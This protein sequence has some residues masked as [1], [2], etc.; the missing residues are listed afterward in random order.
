MNLIIF[1]IEKHAQNV[2][3]SAPNVPQKQ[4]AK[5]VQIPISL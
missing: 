1:N 2:M 3:K 5:N 4:F